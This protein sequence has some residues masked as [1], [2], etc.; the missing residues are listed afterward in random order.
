MD[1]E[2]ENK[3]GPGNKGHS[4]FEASRKEE[5]LPSFSDPSR[6]PAKSTLKDEAPKIS[7]KKLDPKQ[8]QT[9][10]GFLFSLQLLALEYWDIAQAF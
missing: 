5:A 6:L 4:G 10:P 7:V 1:D 2:E 9:L 8:C 3:K